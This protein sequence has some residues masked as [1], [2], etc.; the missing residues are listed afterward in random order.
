MRV[1]VCRE[2]RW[3][4]VRTSKGFESALYA[5]QGRALSFSPLSPCV[6]QLMILSAHKCAPTLLWRYLTFATRA[7]NV[8]ICRTRRRNERR[9]LHLSHYIVCMRGVCERRAVFGGDFV[10]EGY[11]CC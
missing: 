5:R 3:E 4:D 9:P 8:V 1:R 2:G 11:W 7:G 6:P 10:Q